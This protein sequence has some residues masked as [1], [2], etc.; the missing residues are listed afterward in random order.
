MSIYY[1]TIIIIGTSNVGKSSL[2]NYLLGKNIN[3]ISR[4]HYTTRDK[5]R[6]FLKLDNCFIKLI[7][8][9]S[10]I[11]PPKDILEK[12]ILAQINLSIKNADIII[13][14]ANDV[15]FNKDLFYFFKYLT[16]FKKPILLVL[17]KK[18]KKNTVRIKYKLFI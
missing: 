7:D 11:F 6:G 8:T 12:E 18:K 17:N 13:F 3:I 16:W 15:S 10:L 14:V 1:S 2:F 9:G 4:H 5:S